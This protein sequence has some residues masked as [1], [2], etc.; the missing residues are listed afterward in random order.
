MEKEKIKLFPDELPAPRGV[1]AARRRP[2]RAR[3]LCLAA[4]CACIFALGVLFSEAVNNGTIKL[5]EFVHSLNGGQGTTSSGGG[6]TAG[7]APD[8][9]P[10]PDENVFDPDSIYDFD[11]GL[12][13]EGETAIIPADLSLSE[14]GDTYI[15]NDTAFSPDLRALLDKDMSFPAPDSAD[16]PLVLIIHTHTSE[17]YSDE[18]QI[19]CSDDGEYARSDDAEENVIA[20]GA[21]IAEILNE[22]GIN[23]LHCVKSHDKSY[24]DSYAR[25]AETVE[26]YLNKYPSIKY[27]FDVH[28]DSII[29]SSGEIVRPVAAANGGAVAQIMCVVGTDQLGG[30][31]KWEQNL[32]LALKIRSS[33]NEKYGNLARGTCLRSTSYNQELAPISLLFEI[34]AGGNS[35]SEA[36]AAARLLALELAEIIGAER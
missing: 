8:P 1:R 5:P 3:A 21:V 30:D 16:A 35:L 14:Y 20:V 34:G 25:S 29:K 17:A 13:K 18:G 36:K 12:I 11:Y 31:Y 2:R 24:K 26:Y 22:K 27:V 19:A 10:S 28:R 7:G 33:L 6:E 9:E 32:S 4:L 15:Y 23:T